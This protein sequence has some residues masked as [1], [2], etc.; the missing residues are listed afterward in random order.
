MDITK[1]L[2]NNKTIIF[3]VIV[4]WYMYENTQRINTILNKVRGTLFNN[5]FVILNLLTG[6]S[7]SDPTLS[8]I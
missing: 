3:N 2:Y 6:S 8:S 5:I 7:F 4:D 1:I